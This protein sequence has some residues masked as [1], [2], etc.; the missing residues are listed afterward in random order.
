MERPRPKKKKKEKENKKTYPNGARIRS[1][2]KSAKIKQFPH[3]DVNPL[4]RCHINVS[5]YS[6]I[7]SNNRYIHVIT[8]QVQAS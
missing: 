2:P 6:N 1:S 3:I 8:L 4:S 7:S 5:S